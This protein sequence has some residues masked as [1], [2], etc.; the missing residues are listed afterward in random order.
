MPVSEA[1]KKANEKYTKANYDEIKV[2]V[3]KGRKAEI[4]AHAEAHGESV[5]SFI[6][7]AVNET[8]ERDSPVSVALSASPTKSPGNM[9]EPPKSVTKSQESTTKQEKH[10]KPFTDADARLIDLSEL[11]TNVK[12]QLDIWETFGKDV[13]AALM[14]KARQQEAEKEAISNQ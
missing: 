6:V 14:E 11:L 10:C 4:K 5:N 9:T 1:R 12:Y 7:R 13:L 8:M 2:R 3:P